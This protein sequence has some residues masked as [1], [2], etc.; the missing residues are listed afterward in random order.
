[1]IKRVA[2]VGVGLIGSSLGL[3]LKELE[4]IKEVVGIDKNEEYLEEALTIG[5]IDKKAD[6]IDGV[7]E[8]DLLIFATP[9]GVVK[10]LV[11]MV[12]PYLKE[13]TI[14]TDVGSTKSILVE[15]I[16]EVVAD[17]PYVGGHPMTGSEVVGPTGADKYLFENAIYVLTETE[18]TDKEDLNKLKSLLEGIGAQVLIL[19][20]KHH[21]Q[22]VALTSHLPHIVAVNLMNVIAK[23][24]QDDELITSLT[25]GG[26]RDT[27]RIAA[28]DPTMWRDIFLANKDMVLES[29]DYFQEALEEFKSLIVLEEDQG[30]FDNLAQARQDRLEVPIKKK[31]L[32]PTNYELILTLEDRPNAIGEV[33]YLLGREEINIQDI[34]VLKVREDGGTLRLS[35]VKEEEQIKGCSLLKEAGYKVIKKK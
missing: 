25:A 5:A 15:E 7:K 14:I 20:P 33:A 10:P 13:G 19:S 9:V 12:I 8:V 28:G 26:F 21:D 34:E 4:D 17:F 1:M 24:S 30:L 29:I 31:G 11:E 16:E 23:Q 18:K 3:A 32:L 2:I 27:T 35:F 6:L 22:I